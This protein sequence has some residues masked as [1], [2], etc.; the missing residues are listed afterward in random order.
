MS[1]QNPAHS[2]NTALCHI[3]DQGTIHKIKLFSVTTGFRQTDR[4]ANVQ[5]YFK[6]ST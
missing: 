3:Q 2:Y 5:T 6:L 1:L 4:T